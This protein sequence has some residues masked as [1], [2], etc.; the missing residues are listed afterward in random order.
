[1]V[2]KSLMLKNFRQYK[3]EQTITFSTD[4]EKNV[5]VILGVNTSGKTTLVEAF[6]W[7]F[8][9][10]TNFR[11]KDLL[12][13]EILAEMTF[14]SAAEVCV[15]VVLV[16]EGKEFIIRRCQEFTKKNGRLRYNKATIKVSYKDKSGAQH[17]IPN[18]PDDIYVKEAIDK[19][20]PETLS[21]YFFFGGERIS[22]INKRGDVVSAVRGLMGLDVLINAM[23]RLDPT[24]GSSVVSQLNKALDL[25]SEK[26]GDLYLREIDKA[27]ENYEIALSKKNRISE[28]ISNYNKRKE[29][30]ASEILRNE[31]VKEKQERK[32]DLER[33][34]ALFDSK[35]E[36]SE[37]RLNDYFN[38]NAMSFFA[39]PLIDKALNVIR[40]AKQDS[41]GIPEMRAKAIDYLI[42]RGRCIC[43]CDLT[44]SS[45]AMERVLYEK[46]LLPPQY[47]GTTLRTYT[48]TLKKMSNQTDKIRDEIIEYYK[49]YRENVRIQEEKK[50]L[51]EH[52]SKE[53]EGCYDVQRAELDYRNVERKLQQLKESS[54]EIIK[55]IGV[56]ENEINNI[57]RKIDGLVL[58]NAKNERVS[59]CIEYAK[60]VFDWF[61]S[62][63][64]RQEREVKERL[65][66]SVNR[67]FKDMYHGD[68]KVILDENYNIELLTMMGDTTITTE[69][70]KGLEA[71][72]NFSFICGLVDLA[73]QKARKSDI[74]SNEDM[75]II[76]DDGE[77]EI[78][79]EPYPLVMDAP[80]SNVDEIHINNIAKVLPEVAEQV[81][82][83]LMKKDWEFAK[84]SLDH[85]VGNK[86][87]IEKINNSET[88]S[89]IK[90]MVY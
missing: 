77:M 84:N 15:E 50:D 75:D 43:G 78:N 83:M 7:C 19:I 86:Y 9:G 73:R 68:R 6:N 64:N 80:F 88:Y 49:D 35:I 32:M 53:I 54:I 22:D 45:V 61:K 28:E 58:A 52:I 46:R 62:N 30:L 89:S 42:K 72:K 60:R 3:G 40:D 56:Y 4:N 12:N 70:S 37:K 16:H 74:D 17:S 10:K 90:P 51:R 66:E 26:N 21:D 24:K 79:T 57:Q 8:Y 55:D 81:I 71:V 1:M 59:L 76:G 18:G 65:L 13:S 25:D 23:D 14:Y 33:D 34:I 31:N 27:K 63:Y 5:T 69:E 11:I 39:F 44:S 67:I 87:V 36:K 85:R 47:I 38:E 82:I 20:L 48:Q 41:E 29:E 2:I